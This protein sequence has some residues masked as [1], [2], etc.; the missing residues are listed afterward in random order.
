MLKLMIL[1]WI[2]IGAVVVVCVLVML[3]ARRDS[4]LR[5]A[6][7]L[8]LE[9]E[10]TM[11]DVE[12]LVRAGQKIEAIRVYREIHPEVGLAEAKQAVEKLSA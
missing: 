1:L 6:G 3:L 7:V 8:P 12:R 4:A 9:G 2:L 11:A 10:G 5:R